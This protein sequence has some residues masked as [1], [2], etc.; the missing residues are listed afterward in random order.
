MQS[1]GRSKHLRM[2]GKTLV[3]VAMPAVATSSR[4]C[5]IIYIHRSRIFTAVVP[6]DF[7]GD[8][9]VDHGIQAQEVAPLIRTRCEIDEFIRV[10]LRVVQLEVAVP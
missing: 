2:A 7:T 6:S 4:Q 1:D 9:R 10:G 3:Q 8:Q 5:A